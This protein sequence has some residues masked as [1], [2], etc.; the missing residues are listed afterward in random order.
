MLRIDRVR[1]TDRTPFLYSINYLPDDIGRFLSKKELEEQSLTELIQKK[2]V[3][4][5]KSALQT[6]SATLADDHMADILKVPIGFPL[7]EIKRVTSS[8]EDRPINLFFGFFRPDLYV[9]TAIFHY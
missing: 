6:F 7:L 4:V 8:V 3:F 1:L 5:L 2:C 9:F